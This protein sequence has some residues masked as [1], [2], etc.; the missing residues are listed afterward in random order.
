MKKAFNHYRTLIRF[1][2]ISSICLFFSEV[3]PQENL[4]NEISTARNFY[5]SARFEEAI[6]K[7]NDLIKIESASEKQRVEA[8]QL[9]GFA[10]VA[11]GYY[12]QAKE[13]VEKIIELD[14]NIQFDPEFVPPKMM[15]IYYAVWK[16][17][18]GTNQIENQ[19]DPGIQTIAIL[20]FDN[21]SIGDD[22]QIWEPMGKGLAQML[23]TDLSKIVKLKVVERERIQYI[24]DELKLQKSEAFDEKSVVQIGKQLGVHA[25]LFG[26]FSKI[27]KMVRIDAR[28]IKVETSE[29]IKAE[30]IT[31]K[32]EEFINLEKELALKIT[33]NLDVELSKYEGKLIEKSE[34][35]SLEAA[36]AYSEGLSLL[37]RDDY[38]NAMR[39]F[40]EA[41]KYN[42]NY[43]AA[44]KKIDLI[45]PLVS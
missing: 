18:Q 20:D 9:L 12:A 8:Y 33:K 3:I 28:L 24:L 29:L 25:M 41:L 5:N 31:G 44:Q 11:K 36:L 17:K 21:N 45:K 10:L 4:A 35:R 38:K 16:E 23:I 32:A 40:Q 34:N 37:D 27:D 6:T 14:P 2:L 22:K 30:E 26:G 1:F 42:P 13:A 43:A 19:N 39:K 15:K 7:L